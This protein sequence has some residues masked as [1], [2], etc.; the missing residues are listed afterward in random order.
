MTELQ[1]IYPL[2]GYICF[3]S[4]VISV[5]V[6]V[7]KNYWYSLIHLLS[8]SCY[9]VPITKTRNTIQYLFYFLFFLVHNLQYIFT[10]KIWSTPCLFFLL[11][12][13]DNVSVR[14]QFLT[15]S[16]RRSSSRSSAVQRRLLSQRLLKYDY[17]VVFV[18]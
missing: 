14:T 4:V 10:P 15:C 17:V 16:E 3:R 5:G 6:L 8:I 13:K 12:M 1:L 9:N 2:N 7:R 11:Q 18:K